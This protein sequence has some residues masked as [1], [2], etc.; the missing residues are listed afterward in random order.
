MLVLD[1][2][3]LSQQPFFEN[4]LLFPLMKFSKLW[5]DSDADLSPRGAGACKGLGALFAL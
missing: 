1:S 5:L 2:E 3:P 4:S